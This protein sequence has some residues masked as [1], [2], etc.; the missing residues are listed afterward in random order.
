M[1][2]SDRTTFQPGQYRSDTLNASPIRGWTVR[3][4]NT[5]TV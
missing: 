2:R 3:P 4:H 1:S 5:A